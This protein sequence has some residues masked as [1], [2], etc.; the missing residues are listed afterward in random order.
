MRYETTTFK[1]T[2][3][4]SKLVLQLQ[5]LEGTVIGQQHMLLKVLNL[6]LTNEKFVIKFYSDE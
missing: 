1:N 6:P 2:S 5:Q 3:N 4:S